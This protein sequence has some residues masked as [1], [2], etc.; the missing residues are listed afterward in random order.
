M[1]TVRELI[2]KISF[3]YNSQGMQQAQRAVNQ[4]LRTLRNLNKQNPRIHADADTARAEQRL[5]RLRQRISDI[6]NQ[7]IH[8][9]DGGGHAGGGVGGGPGGGSGG[10]FLGA[11]G[12]GKLTA[13]AVAAAGVT[14]AGAAAVSA[15]KTFADFDA[16]MSKVR[17][18][19]NASNNDMK[20][21]TD[22]AQKL[23]ATTQF[24]A[25]QAAEA[26]TYLGMAGWKTSEIV[27]GMPGLLN[28]AAA[29][30]MDLA[31]TADIVSDDLTAFHMDADQAGHMADVMAAASTNAN[32]NVSLMGMTFKYAGAVAGSLGYSLEDVAIATGL[33][34]NAGIKGE[35]AGTALRSVMTRMIDPPKEA[36]MALDRLGVSA[37]NAD[38]TVKPF[39]QQLK[40]LRAAFS[41]LSK[42]EQAEAASS[43]AGLEAM[44]GFLSVVTASDKDFDKLAA[45]IDNS[46]GSADKMAATMNDNLT[47]SFTQLGSAVESVALKFGKVL[48]PT[49]RKSIDKVRKYVANIS[50]DMS[51]YEKI[52]EAHSL[53]NAGDVKTLDKYRGENN[54]TQLEEQH[55][56]F[57]KALDYWERFSKW[58]DEA[59]DRLTGRFLPIFERLGGYLD[60]VM[61][62]KWNAVRENMETGLKYL[63]DAW[64]NLQPTIEVLVNAIGIALVGAFRFVMIVGSAAF[65]VIAAAIDFASILLGSF[66]EA[67]KWVTEL[68][69]G[70]FDWAVRVLE[71]IGLIESKRG[72]LNNIAV[73]RL[74]GMTNLGQMSAGNTNT[75]NQENSFTFNVSSPAQAQ[76]YQERALGGLMPDFGKGKF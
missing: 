65:R 57:V 3:Q 52:A 9:R 61:G 50:A 63:G 76:S 55:P 56:I 2:T 35:M 34:A 38:G 46:K 1:G 70:A 62:D 68:L 12:I 28:L 4:L 31:T 19:T 30:G 66:G 7:R 11:M 22:T 16:M 47:G 48:E 49:A 14:A 67:V 23:G 25:T 37:T 69:Q 64:E 10:E 73:D 8:I 51:D 39:R 42:A 24:S 41:N 29:S 54:V 40:E 75:V 6:N 53:A 33:M 44:S 27:K 18:L 15:V 59:S 74:F 13:G 71:Q 60:L 36:A 20:T 17:A 21:L 26:M 58:I 43:I 72:G 45:A 5:Q 32:T